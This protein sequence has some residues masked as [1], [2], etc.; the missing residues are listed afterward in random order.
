MPNWHFKRRVVAAAACLTLS[1][2]RGGH[3]I[4]CS[5]QSRA[6]QVNIAIMRAFVRL[7]EMLLTRRSRRK[8]AALEAKYDSQFK[9]VFDAIRQLR[10]LPIR[11]DAASVSPRR[12]IILSYPPSMPFDFQRARPLLQSGNLAKL[13]VEELAGNRAARN[14]RC[15]QGKPIS[16]FLPLPRNVGSLLGFA[17]ARM[18][19]CRTTRRD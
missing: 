7:R 3:A 15:A 2:N 11:Q 1:P 10:H 18:G 16:P 8:L 9:V 17:V 14:S 12:F 13:F 19:V 5:E 4:Q 6:V